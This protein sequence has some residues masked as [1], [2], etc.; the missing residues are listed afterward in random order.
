MAVQ[1]SG[2]VLTQ[3]LDLSFEQD[4]V[5]KKSLPARA[6]RDVEDAELMSF[7]VGLS[8]WQVFHTRL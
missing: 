6:I 8:L 4:E 5:V 3:F 1:F 2:K 7:F